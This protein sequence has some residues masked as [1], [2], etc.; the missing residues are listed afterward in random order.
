[1]PQETLIPSELSINCLVHSIFLRLVSASKF[2][3]L[4]GRLLAVNR[5]KIFLLKQRVPKNVGG[6]SAFFKV[7]AQRGIRHDFFKKASLFIA[8][9]I[10]SGIGHFCPNS[11]G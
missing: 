9:R 6:K 3:L 11:N 2:S 1:M 4:C 7:T 10:F 8:G 5:Q